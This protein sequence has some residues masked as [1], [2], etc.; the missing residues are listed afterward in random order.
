[1]LKLAVMALVG[2]VSAVGAGQT[3]ASLKNA[4]QTPELRA[5]VAIAPQSSMAQPASIAKGR[6]GH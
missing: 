4:N 5:A 2:A 3:L 6:D 1:M